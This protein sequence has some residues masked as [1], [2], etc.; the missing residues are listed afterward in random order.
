MLNM[1]MKIVTKNMMMIKAMK[2]MRET[3]DKMNVTN[4]FSQ[5]T[6]TDGR[7]DGRTEPLEVPWCN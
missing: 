2:M 3:I 1:M 6:V 4:D 7:T 5:M